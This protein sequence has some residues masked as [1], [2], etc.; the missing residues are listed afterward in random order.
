MLYL[1]VEFKFNT[2][3]I[4]RGLLKEIYKACVE[5][6]RLGFSFELVYGKTIYKLFIIL[7]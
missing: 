1:K 4:H 3:D 7:Q 5:E 6:N 2:T